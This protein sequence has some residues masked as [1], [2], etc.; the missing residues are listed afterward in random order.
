MIGAAAI[1]VLEGAFLAQWYHIGLHHVLHP[2]ELALNYAIAGLAGAV[3]L[4][5]TLLRV[6]PGLVRVTGPAVVGLMAGGV[7]AH[8]LSSRVLAGAGEAGLVMAVLV[9]A[10]VALGSAVALLLPGARARLALD[11]GLLAVVALGIARP[12]RRPDEPAAPPDR[13]APNVL[14]I[15]IDTLRADRLGI[16]GGPRPTSPVIDSLA[17]VGT[18]FTRFYAASSWTLPSTASIHTGLFPEGHGAVTYESAVPPDAPR[19]ARDFRRAG[20]ATAAF[21]E[22]RFVTPRFGFGPGFDVFRAYWFPWVHRHT[23]LHRVARRLSLPTLS[24]TEKEEYPDVLEDPR[25]LNWDARVTADR[26]ASWIEDRDRR[27]FFAYVHFMGP[28]GPYGPP[29]FLLPGDPPA[30]PLANHP[31]R[32]GAGYPIGSRGTPVSDVELADILLHYDADIRYVDAAIG[33]LLARIRAAGHAGRT[34]VIVTSDHGEEFFDHAG[35]NHGATCFEEMVHVPLVVAGPGIAAGARVETPARHVDLRPT[36][37][38]LI[39]RGT[40]DT[41]PPGGRS[42]EAVVPGRSLVPALE[43][44]TAPFPPIPVLVEGAVHRPPDGTVDAVVHDGWKLIRVRVGDEE[45]L[46]LHDLGADPQEERPL[47]GTGLARRDS[48]L[49][50]LL[51]WKE[52]ARAAGTSE[53]GI[54]LDPGLLETLRNLGYVN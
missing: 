40:R 39:G 3:V 8:L 20:Y 45:R 2:L 35:W 1:G 37:R 41:P 47:D 50:E 49:R 23:F 15:V 34:V 22:N 11:L 51:L 42:D 6:R 53:A 30:R 46:L 38:E 33:D 31:D 32:K 44:R 52:V 54:R 24:V 12:D 17:A 5:G 13:G 4:G 43:G 26:A 9:A 21:S 7:V 19:I 18:H 29:E 10:I 16:H 28:H 36:L 14:L 25:D 27:P 48:L